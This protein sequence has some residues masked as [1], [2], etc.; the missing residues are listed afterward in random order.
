M[1][2]KTDSPPLFIDGDCVESVHNI[3]FLG[4]HIS[5]GLIWPVSILVYCITVWY[6]GCSALQRVICTPWKIIVCPLPSLEEI[7]NTLCLSRAS[8]TIN[9]CTHPGQHLFDFLPSGKSYRSLNTQTNRLSH[10]FS[11]T[12]VR[13]LNTLEYTT[14]WVFF[15]FFYSCSILNLQFLISAFWFDSLFIS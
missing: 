14:Q 15:F 8:V 9:D 13:T 7:A 4:T 3:K 5:D 2:T 10:S 12:A 1:Q 6:V 11:P